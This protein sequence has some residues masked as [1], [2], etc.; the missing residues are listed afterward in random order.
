MDDY[1]GVSSYI[2]RIEIKA[3]GWLLYVVVPQATI[4]KFLQPDIVT[5][6]FSVLFL[7]VS[8]VVVWMIIRWMAVQQNSASAQEMSG[9]SA[10]LQELISRFKI[11]NTAEE[12]PACALSS[13]YLEKALGIS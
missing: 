13:D 3:S 7:I 1:N 9:Q 12:A 4:A 5:I 2:F 10:M 8:E 6:I 11:K